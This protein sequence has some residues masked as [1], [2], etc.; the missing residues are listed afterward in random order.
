MLAT[1]FSSETKKDSKPLVYHC[2][3]KSKPFL[4]SAKIF[5]RILIALD[6]KNAPEAA[7]ILG[8]SKQAVYDWQ[9]N[10]PSVENLLRVAKSRN[11]SLHWILTGEGERSATPEMSLSIDQ[12]LE[13]KIRRIVRLEL[14]LRD[15]PHV[16]IEDA[17]M[18]LAPNI[19]RVGDEIPEEVVRKA[20]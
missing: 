8:I 11:S 19:G 17:E 5:E 18:I 2:Q 6:A 16:S 14:A 12:L 1:A 13:D 4:D 10:T 15:H 9:K 3:V 7:R 20:N